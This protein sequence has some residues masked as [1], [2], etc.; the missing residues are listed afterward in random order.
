[1]QLFKRQGSQYRGPV[2]G[3]LQLLVVQPTPF[4]NIQCDYCYLPNRDSTA[5]LQKQT[6]R[7]LLETVFSSGLVD[8][9][10]SI[11]WH[12]G[13]PLALPVSFYSDLFSVIDELGI[14]PSQIRHSI[15]TNGMLISE[16][17]CDFFSE[18]EVNV[19]LSIDG[20]AHIHDSHRIDRQRKGT[21]HRVLKGV[22]IL[23][24]RNIDFHVIAV[25]TS[26]SLDHADEI[27]DF[28]LG[29]GVARLGF[30]VEELEGEHQISS[31]RDRK[32]EDRIRGFWARLYER[33]MASEGRLRIR[34]FERAYDN[35]VRG[36][37]GVTATQSMQR[38]S[39]VL[40]FAIIG[41]DCRGNLSTFSPE[42]L[43]LKSAQYGDFTFGNVHR[44]D[45]LDIRKTSNFDAVAT[46]I[47]AG[48]K[49]CEKSCQYFDLCGGGAPANKYY[50]NGSFVS[51]ETMYC[52]TSIQMP[53]DVVLM[54]L[55]RQI[56]LRTTS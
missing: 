42:L 23:Q 55:E 3:S 32:L 53:I 21:H 19:G 50:E 13:E 39:Q 34:E 11:V 28:F 24:E 1:L 16:A 20:P 17:W 31:L 9:T 22:T 43:G 4:C 29:L 25:V 46:D 15:Q 2:A 6:F 35:I 27:F 38:N 51:T 37:A 44:G 52:R 7:R 30:N 45:L 41:M 5:R 54:G 48:V 36:P 26:D 47:Y 10:L 49:A 18:F 14:R 56:Q 40:P 33:Q 12:A 8:D